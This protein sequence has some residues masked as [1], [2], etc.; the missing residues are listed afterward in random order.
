MLARANILTLM[1]H[2]NQL[3]GVRLKRNG[4]VITRREDDEGPD[5]FLT[6]SELTKQNL[7][8]K[9]LELDTVIAMKL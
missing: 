5:R 8:K 3:D 2:F 1:T 7:R 6:I 9:Q 4:V